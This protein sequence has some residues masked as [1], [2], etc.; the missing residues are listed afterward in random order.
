MADW[1]VARLLAV[2]TDYLAGRGSSSPRLDAELLLAQSLGMQ[3]ID[4][5]VQHDRPLAAAEVDAY[6]ELVARRAHH[7]PVAYIL[8][9]ASFRYLTLEV[10][11]DVLIPRPETEEL[12]DAVLSWL[13]TRPMLDEPIAALGPSVVPAA[14]EDM[15]AAAAPLIADV[16]TGSGAIALSL[17]S[18]TGLPVLG[19]EVSPAALAVAIRNR[20][21]L[22]VGH[23]VEL[24]AGDL[25]EGLRDGSL[26]LIVSNP[27]YVSVAEYEGLQPEV[28]DH[29]PP[30]A[31]VAGVDG[32]DVYRRLL[33]QAARV[34]APG[35]AIVL[36]VGDGQA[37]QVVELAVAAGLC[38]SAVTTDLSGKRR[39]VRAL[40]P[41][42][43]VLATGPLTPNAAS[44]LGAALRAGALVG[45]PT[46]TVYGVA[47]AWDSAPG[48]RGLFAAKGR[49]EH[50]PVAAIFASVS[51][52]QESL[53]DLDPL[54][55]RVLASLLPGPYTFVV[56]TT[57]SRPPLVG[58]EDSL[59]VRVPDH[60][61][62]LAL[63]ASLGTAIAA[64]SANVS[65]APAPATRADVDPELL[66]CCAVAFGGGPGEPIVGVASTVVDL[67]P[68][69]RG[70]APTVLRE[71]A[72]TAA[73][74]LAR[75]AAALSP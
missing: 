38:R 39:I 68:L 73:D 74:A 5:Y 45:I 21:A 7:E 69:T 24:R 19:L 51:A 57:V 42:A 26:R 47:A 29:E 50:S 60:P 65:G 15:R 59:G 23:L 48:V 10:G 32:L 17:A 30:G 55:A 53:P 62:L 37:D 22:D 63:L 6:R 16:G 56:A 49:G 72:V 40:R 1:T 46:D 34:L 54:V 66:A 11:P 31:L 20:D 35:G 67:R 2:S 70:G 18:E 58:T 4:L 52:V 14:P 27:P 44:A 13:R 33:P 12:V 71:G 61:P 43:M 9:R 3:R 36:E 75:I 8:G 28:R 25:L 41:G 64:T